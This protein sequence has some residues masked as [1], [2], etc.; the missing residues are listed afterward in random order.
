MLETLDLLFV[1]PQYINHV[2]FGLYFNTTYAEH[3]MFIELI[4]NSSVF[5]VIWNLQNFH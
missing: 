2:H 1:H 4:K 3:R 5:T